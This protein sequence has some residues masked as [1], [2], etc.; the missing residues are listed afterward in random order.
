MWRMDAAV[1]C[2]TLVNV[3]SVPSPPSMSPSSLK[4]YQVTERIGEVF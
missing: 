4:P 3:F 2:A 1:P